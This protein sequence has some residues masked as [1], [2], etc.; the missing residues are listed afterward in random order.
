M[1]QSS[2]SNSA[3]FNIPKVSIDHYGEFQCQ[4]EKRM[5]NQTFSFLSN[6]VNLTV[7]LPEP[8]ISISPAEVIWGQQ[9]NITCSVEASPFSGTFILQ[10]TSRSFRM[11]QSSNSSSATFSISKVTL[12]HDGEFKC[13]YEKRMSNQT[14]TSV[15]SDFVRL[16]VNLPKPNISISPAA[17]VTWGQQ[18]IITCSIAI[19][20]FHYG[21]FTLQ[22]T[23]GSF[24]MTQPSFSGSET[25][26]IQKVTLDHDGEFLC[27]YRS[28]QIFSSVRSDS[29]HLTVNL[30]KPNISISSAEVTWGQQVSI[31][32]SMAAT[33][34]TSLSGTFILQQTSGSFR[35]TRSSYSSSATF[36]IPKVTLDH[37]GEFKCQFE[38][39]MLSKT[40][41]SLLSNSVRLNVSLERPNISLTSPN[42]GLV[43]G[44]GGAEVIKGYGFSFTCSINPRY[45]QGDFSLIFSGSNIRETR[46]AVK[47]SASFNFP[48]SE[49]EHQGSYS[50]VYEVTMT[51]QRFSSAQTEPISLV[52]KASSQLLVSSVS[53]GILL[54]V[55]LVS[56]AVCL[57]CRRKLCSK[58]PIPSDQNQISFQ[59]LITQDHENDYD[60][61]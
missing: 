36:N 40:F 27:Q 15:Y 13:Q 52:L 53:S 42:A 16:T 31:T 26:N 23:S 22:K 19:T 8:N 21:T 41:T 28:R 59:H 33:T 57:G 12:D 10:Q 1:N 5:S 54:L 45:P 6:S 37:D 38:K 60:D 3:S 43:W 35:M 9:L 39:R 4:Y 17:E 29:V 61:Y 20:Q 24:R 25:F 44:A 56:L 51:T 49:F 34:F 2:D 50:C 46:P 7:R 14:L 18:V 55:L 30:P 58:R 32:C 11:T 48:T 47:N